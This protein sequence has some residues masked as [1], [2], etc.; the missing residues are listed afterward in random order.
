MIELQEHPA[1]EVPTLRGHSAPQCPCIFVHPLRAE[2]YTCPVHGCQLEPWD[3]ATTFNFLLPD[4]G[5]CKDCGALRYSHPLPHN[6][7]IHCGCQIIL[8]INPKAIR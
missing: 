6:P 2:P 1:A 5:W 7:C 3:S 4:R 8:H